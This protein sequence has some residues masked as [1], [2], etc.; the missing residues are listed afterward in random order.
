MFHVPTQARTFYHS[1]VAEREATG[2]EDLLNLQVNIRSAWRTARRTVC[3]QAVLEFSGGW[4]LSGEENTSMP[5]TE[6]MFRLQNQLGAASRSR[7]HCL[8]HSCHS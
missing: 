6:R 2:P 8:L 5:F 4:A 3:L 1:C 7:P